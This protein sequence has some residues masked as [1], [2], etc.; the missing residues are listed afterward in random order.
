MPLNLGGGPAARV[1]AGVGVDSGGVGLG[2][3]VVRPDGAPVARD[4]GVAASVTPASTVAV[5]VG[6]I[7]PISQT[8]E[9][10]LEAMTQAGLIQWSGKALEPM[11]PVARVRGDGTVSD[12]LVEDRD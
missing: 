12:L 10:R 2:C 6:R 5:N 8:L 11:P 9:Q 3:S 4:T 1:A 7:V